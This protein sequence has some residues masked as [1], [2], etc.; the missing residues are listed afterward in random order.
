MQR[1]DKHV[2]TAL[3]LG[4]PMYSNAGRYRAGGIGV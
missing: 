1:T 3:L 2:D 4:V